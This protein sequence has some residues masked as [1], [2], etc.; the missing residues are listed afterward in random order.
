ML[1]SE[2]L[3][4]IGRRDGTIERW[5]PESRALVGAP[6]LGHEGSTGALAATRVG[7]R[8][9]L[10]SSDGRTV[11]VWDLA[12]GDPVGEPIACKAEVVAGVLVDGRITI[13]GVTTSNWTEYFDLET[14]ERQGRSSDW[15]GPRRSS[16]ARLAHP[17]L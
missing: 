10:L 7:D 5:H 15:A 6:M 3:V 8:S 14:R 2:S 16:Q 11:R 4:V 17:G 1:A 9:L 12:S 13:A